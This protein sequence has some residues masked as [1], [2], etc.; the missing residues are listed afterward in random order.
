MKKIEMFNYFSDLHK[1]V[2]GVR[3]HW[4]QE[5]LDNTSIEELE[6]KI[7]FFEACRKSRMTHMIGKMLKIFLKTT[8][9]NSLF[10]ALK[11][12]VK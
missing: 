10:L 11:K 12:N 3:P 4:T 1:D 7:K 2:Y 9:K 5:E 6:E 8:M